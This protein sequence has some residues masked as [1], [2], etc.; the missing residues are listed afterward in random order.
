MS[1]R[2]KTILILLLTMVVLVI[3]TGIISRQLIMASYGEHEKYV[4]REATLRA[5][6][7]IDEELEHMEK[8][9]SDWSSWDDT[10]MFMMGKA[11]GYINENMMNST[12]INLGINMM[13]LVDTNGRVVFGK[14]VDLKTGLE[15]ETPTEFNEALPPDGPILK[16]GGVM[17][18][19]L[20]LHDASM[21]VTA[22]PIL[23]SNG[24]GPSVGTLIIGR[25]LDEDMGKYVAEVSRSPLNIREWTADPS[26]GNSSST[27]AESLGDV[28]VQELGLDRIRGSI[29]IANVHNSGG[30]IIDVEMPRHVLAKGKETAAFYNWA[31]VVLSFAFI[32]VLWIMLDVFVLRR[33]RVLHKSVSKIARNSN[34][35]IRIPSLG[36]D[37]LAD[38]AGSINR[39]LE[40][41]YYSEKALGIILGVA[42]L[43]LIVLDR[44]GVIK[45]WNHQAERIMGWSAD[46]VKGRDD[47]IVGS[48][49]RTDFLQFIDFAC[50]SQTMLTYECQAVCKNGTPIDALFVASSTESSEDEEDKIV[51]IIIDV[52]VRKEA[53]RALKTT[54][55]IQ[56]TL[57]KEIHHRI[58]NNLQAMSSVLDVGILETDNP[59]ARKV[60][61][62]GLAR[63]NA[64]AL[65]HEKLYQSND[66]QRVDLKPYV[67]DLVKNIAR[68]FNREGSAIELHIDVQELKLN[69]ETA[70]SCGLMINELVTNVFKY[71]Y[72]DGRMGTMTLWLG[73]QGEGTY[74]L[75][76]SDDGNGMPSE[77][78]K[79]SMGL[80]IVESLARQL[81]GSFKIDSNGGTRVTVQFREA[82][83][84]TSLNI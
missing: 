63:I 76:V 33:L 82:V 3:G 54:L 22:R 14:S 50:T 4:I 24:H 10:R 40:Q 43:P 75:T 1:I 39:M 26:S 80:S 20:S 52:T 38:L 34:H 25:W 71:A 8:T 65:V 73:E 6:E 49:E 29:S 61:W 81:E 64:M 12:Y 51:M 66:P 47:L 70:V 60:I 32:V 83:E 35:Q 21:L 41:L 16:H 48:G 84:M 45:T 77:C 17:K 53:E 55:D 9:N 67:E 37:E 2:V 36:N 7:V 15:V 5:S 27:T 78:E 44:K 62:D 23:D 68:T 57:L 69:S 30:I 79:S 11:P 56:D 72:P 13:I 46:E 18:G 74:H 31:L 28:V 58:K 59:E 19:I 42:R